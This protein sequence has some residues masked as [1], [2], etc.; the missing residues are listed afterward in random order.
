MTGA[1]KSPDELVDI[2]TEWINAYPRCIMLI[3]PFRYAVKIFIFFFSKKNI[4]V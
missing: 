4:Y 1:P 3:D 2:Y